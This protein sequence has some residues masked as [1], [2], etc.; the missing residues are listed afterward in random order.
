MDSNGTRFHLLHG[1]ADW[2]AC[3]EAR[4]DGEAPP[5]VWTDL[6]WDQADRSLRLRRRP[7]A[8]APAARADAPG[9]EARRGAA[10]DAYGN[11]Y[12]I[13]RARTGLVRLPAGD[14]RPAPYWRQTAAPAPTAAGFAPA[15]APPAPRELSGLTVTRSH[16]LLVGA[17][18]ELLIFDLH[19]GGPPALL[20]MPPPFRPFALA[21]A[22]DGGAWVLDRVRR[23]VWRLD[24]GLR[25]RAEALSPAPAVTMPGTAAAFQ[26]P[27]GAAEASCTEP[28][29]TATGLALAA[30]DPIALTALPDDTLVVLDAASG[31]G[32]RLYLVARDGLQRDLGP[33]SPAGIPITAHDLAYDPQGDLIYL[34]DALGNRVHAYHPRPGS[35]PDPQSPSGTRPLYAFAGRAL[36]S[37]GRGR[38]C[39]DLGAVGGDDARVRWPALA[40]L[41][42]TFRHAHRALCIGPVLDGREEACVWDGLFLDA[43]IPPGTAVRVAVRGHDRPELVASAPFVDQ[44][45]LYRRGLGAEIPYY[46][47]YADCESPPPGAGSYELLLQEVRGRYL[48]VRLELIGDGATSPLVRSLRVY[49]PRFSYSERYLPAVYREDPA[50]ASFLERLLANFKGFHTHLEGRM[51]AVGMLFDPRGAP[52]DALDWLAGWLGLALDP[53][54]GELHRHADAPPRGDRRRLLLRL[55]PLLF[56]RRGTPAGIRLALHLLLDPCLEARLERFGRARTRPDPG[57]AAQLEGIGL[58]VPAPDLDDEALEALFF[59]FLVSPRRPSRIR[60]IERFLTRAKPAADA[61]ADATTGADLAHRFSVLL[62]EGVDAD[63]RRM[64]ERLVDLEKPAHTAYDL[65]RYWEGFRVGEARLGLDTLLGEGGRFRPVTLGAGTLGEGFLAAA[66]ALNA[67]DR[68]LLDRNPPGAVPS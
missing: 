64:V 25:M 59:A 54:W 35:P 63:L 26:S 68:V 52:P 5:G 2:R 1:Q 24:A 38:V 57:L 28:R 48:Q 3:A 61:T 33:L 29:P 43:R 30:A 22:P 14:K 39:Y 12:W 11:L 66:P 60:L 44:P 8:Q 47:P 13:D 50:S 17:P 20:A 4:E 36:V 46:E 21:A 32:P 53:L 58:R 42:A 67:G 16:Y 18:G 37:D 31:T 55:A 7:R 6:D 65:R 9:L 15:A 62:P 19:G 23:R 56:E 41:P 10:L 40:T 49:Y 45:P 34:A 27:T 51:A